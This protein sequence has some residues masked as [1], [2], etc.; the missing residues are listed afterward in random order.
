MRKAKKDVGNMEKDPKEPDNHNIQKKGRTNSSSGG[1]GA[2]ILD[3]FVTFE[4]SQG[5]TT[6]IDV[7]TAHL[8]PTCGPPNR[9]GFGAAESYLRT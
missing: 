1:V 7:R 9:L 4:A 2:A 5:A 3:I 6:P 8:L